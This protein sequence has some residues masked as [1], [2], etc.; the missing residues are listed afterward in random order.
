[1]DILT[2]KLNSLA[3][4]S[5]TSQQYRELTIAALR[6]ALPFEAACC[7]AVDPITLLSTGAVTE[8]GVETIHNKLLE[9]EYVHDDINVYSDLVRSEIMVATLYQS[10]N[11][12]PE[13]SERYRG[14]LKPA[15]FG[16]ELRAILIT[17]GACWGHLTLFRT[18]EQPPFS[19][20][21]MDLIRTTA[22]IIATEL[23]RFTLTLPEAGNAV[24]KNS[25]PGMMTISTG[26]VPLAS[27]YAASEWLQLLRQ[28]ENI[29]S[30]QLPR[31]IQAVSVRA[32]AD[33]DLPSSA[34]M[35]AA[36]VCLRIPDGTY[37]TL[38]ASKLN[39]LVG[40][41]CIVL[42]FEIAK[43]SDILPLIAKAYDLTPRET[44]IA[45][46]IFRGCSTKEIASTLHISA[47]TVQDH[48][49]SIF[50]KTNVNSRREL[51]WQL[52]TRYAIE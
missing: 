39:G 29:S 46:Q 20:G 12:Q 19:Q 5:Q 9:S 14:V 18:S 40:E 31:P 4:R 27:N 41:N 37:L 11:G 34:S 35:P 13:Q 3:K 49:K 7:S 16:D 8:D 38:R 23:R 45:E 47:Y 25:D 48:L 1:M 15:G 30:D 6:E 43:P 24:N 28:W 2:K 36:K 51:V 33:T 52:F 26:L 10:T 17:D 50:D 42:S 22:P 44:D 21:E 32:L